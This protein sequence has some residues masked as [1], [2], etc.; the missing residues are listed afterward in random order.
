[1]VS[2][3]LGPLLAGITAVAAAASTTTDPAAPTT[4]APTFSVLT[5]T[6][7][8]LTTTFTPPPKCA[9]SHLSMMSPPGYEI[10]LNE[11]M[12]VP[13]PPVANC[14]PSEFM[15]G[16]HSMANSSS[17][18]APFFKP[19][20]CPQGWYTAQEWPNGYIACCNS[21]YL[22]HLPDS[23]VDPD[24]PAYGGTCYSQFTVGQTVNVTKY[25]TASLSGTGKFAATTSVDSAYAHPMD[26]YKVGAVPVQSG[27]A[28]PSDP[29]EKNGLSG[30]RHRRHRDWRGG[31]TWRH[32]RGGLLPLP[33]ARQQ[34][35]QN[36]TNVTVPPATATTEQAYWPKDATSPSVTEQSH[37]AASANTPQW[38]RPPQHEL[39]SPHYA[40]ELD[41][42]QFHGELPGNWHGNELRG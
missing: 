24:R 13:G 34:A 31:G 26:G 28:T 21:G 6:V 7:Q 10:W 19:L 38:Q 42:T 16:Y 41:N 12:P 35:N 15:Q 8:A 14:Y 20:V 30:G 17:S 18:I 4:T 2:L 39:H 9:E 25:G 3:I 40:A 32:R 29:D 36:N 37:D 22:L 1:M 23:T 33:P 27:S 5:I 11:P